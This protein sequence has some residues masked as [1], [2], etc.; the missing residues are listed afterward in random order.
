MPGDELDNTAGRTRAR[1][2]RTM[3]TKTP[4]A[5]ETLVAEIIETRAQLRHLQ[6]TTRRADGSYPADV[7]DL[8]WWLQRQEVMARV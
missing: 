1:E 8:A 5:T 3:T 2:K 7:R 6:A 4:A